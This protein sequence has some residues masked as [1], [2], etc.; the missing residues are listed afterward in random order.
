MAEE[1]IMRTR[2]GSVV[3]EVEPSIIVARHTN[4]GGHL[5]AIEYKIPGGGLYCLPQSQFFALYGGPEYEIEW[6]DEE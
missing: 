5:N 3:K 6:L 1:E 4:C 2:Y